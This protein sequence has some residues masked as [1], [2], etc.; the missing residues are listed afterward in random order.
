[1][2]YHATPL[3]AMGIPERSRIQVGYRRFAC[4]TVHWRSEP[5][6]PQADAL[7]RWTMNSANVDWININVWEPGSAWPTT[8]LTLERAHNLASWVCA[9]M[10]GWTPDAGDAVAH[11]AVVEA[12]TIIAQ[13][14]RRAQT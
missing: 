9:Q 7:L 1:M 14:Q 4:G 11:E 5:T 10:P 12:M 2:T 6:R 13:H 8:T 3:D